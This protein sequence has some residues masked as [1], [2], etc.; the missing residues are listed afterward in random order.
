V[1]VA[2]VRPSPAARPQMHVEGAIELGRVPNAVSIARPA[3]AA[4]DTTVDMYRLDSDGR[5]AER[6]RV[7]LGRGP[8]DRVQV[9]SGLFPGDVV[10][11]SDVTPA[12]GSA[13]HITLR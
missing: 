1:H 10:I 8:A 12:A 2:L 4:D 13:P 7:Q 6:V 9:R 3:G 5:G 11:V